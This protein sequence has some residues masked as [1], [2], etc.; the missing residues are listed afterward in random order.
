MP[1][2]I[3]ETSN[4]MTTRLTRTSF[5]REVHSYWST[6]DVLSVH[7]L[8]SFFGV[9]DR[10]KVNESKAETKQLINKMHN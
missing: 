3:L 7:A 9:V 6:V 10:F 2:E 5:F 4:A 1:R 8:H